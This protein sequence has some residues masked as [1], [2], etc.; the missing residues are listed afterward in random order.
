[1]LDRKFILQNEVAV[2]ANIQ[3][4]NMR[5]DIDRFVDLERQR[6]DLDRRLDET[7]RQANQIAK[8]AP[9][10]DLASKARE[11]EEARRLRDERVRL[12]E[13]LAAIESE[14]A[15]LQMAIPNMTHPAAPVG[16]SDEA[17]TVLGYGRTEP[18]SFDFP[19]RDHLAIGESLDLIDITSGSNVAGRGFYFLKNDAVFLD[20]ALQRFAIDL[21]REE[22]FTIIVTPDLAKAEVLNATGYSPRGN[23]TQ[24]YRIEGTDLGLIATS[25]ITLAGMYANRTFE[26]AE[27]PLLLCGL[28]HCFRTEAGAHGRATRGLYR[29]HQFTK[30]EMFVFCVPE[31]GELWHSRLLEI[32]RRIFDEL[33]I[34]Y[35]YVENATGDLGAAAYRKFDLEAWM[36]GRGDGGEW[37]EVTSAS[38]CTDY[39]ARR[40]NTRYRTGSKP[41]FAYTLNGTAVATGRA[42]IA[43]IENYQRADGGIDVPPVLRRYFGSDVIERRAK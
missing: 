12:K 10:L 41:S 24:I 13:Q 33:A 1:L 35:R 40:L 11:I 6:A 14:V 4:R 32:E 39:Q 38:N 27:L 42:M 7:N 36:P 3:H 20:L 16:A 28:S 23:E 43:I 8:F 19:V 31:Q 15:D 29:V 2:R 9:N 5:V 34:P 37:G 22:G 25:E 30:V 17:N 26:T 21:L 18:R